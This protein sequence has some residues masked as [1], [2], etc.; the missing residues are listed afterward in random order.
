MFDFNNRKLQLLG[1]ALSLAVVLTA[2]SIGIARYLTADVPNHGPIK[3]RDMTTPAQ[4][5]DH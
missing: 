3:A 1:I 4:R 2:W 5:S